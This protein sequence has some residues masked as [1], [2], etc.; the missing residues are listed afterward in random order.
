M[1]A[2]AN[3]AAM[4]ED[5]WIDPFDDDSN[6]EDIEEPNPDH[7]DL[8][9]EPSTSSSVAGDCAPPKKKKRLLNKRQK[10]EILGA[11]EEL[12]EAQMSD[13]VSTNVMKQLHMQVYPERSQFFQIVTTNNKDTFIGTCKHLKDL[14]CDAYR[15]TT[16]G[17][18]KYIQFQVKW[19]K[20][21]SVLLLDDTSNDATCEAAKGIVRTAPPRMSGERFLH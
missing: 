4:D 1:L 7:T 19:H 21:S 13:C 10:Q 20:N 6:D 3:L 9:A 11:L 8:S 17:K 16:K 5:V 12:D 2:V 15:Q 14:F 18:E